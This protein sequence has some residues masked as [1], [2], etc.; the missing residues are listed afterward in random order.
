LANVYE[1]LSYRKWMKDQASEWKKRSPSHTLARLSELAQVQAPYLTNVLK[2]RVHLN[3]DQFFAVANVFAL[4]ADEFQ[5]GQ[6]LL[7]WERSSHPK[8]KEVLQ[9][10]LDEIKKRKLKT[11]TH[12]Q[13]K[14]VNATADELT[15]FYLNPELQL[16]HAFFGV[17]KYAKNIDLIARSLNLDLVQVEALVKE[18]IDLGFL[19]STSSGF[20]KT[21]KSIHLSKTSPLCRP[22]QLLMHHRSLQQ[23]QMLPESERYNFAVLFTADPET[24]ETIHREFLKF[25]S[26]IEETVRKAPSE[27]VY[28]MHFDLF[29]WSRA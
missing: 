25:L 20:E 5:Y 16:I 7:E 22:Q 23:L 13:A 6:T 14:T 4:N 26:T 11:E 29:P 9:S 18:L 15:R 19:K 10:K 17:E 8:R 12:L 24:R 1:Y 3:A 2:E 27:E 28:Q 21:K